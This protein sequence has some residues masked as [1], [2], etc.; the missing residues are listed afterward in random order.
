MPPSPGGSPHGRRGDE[1]APSSASSFLRRPWARALLGLVG[2][3][4]LAVFAWQVDWKA[5]SG[6]LVRL[7]PWVPLLLVPY[8]VVYL[9]DTVG[10]A[11]CLNRFP[12]ISYWR[13]FR[14]RW[15]GEAV[16]SLVPS[17]YIAGE[18]VKVLLLGRDGVSGSEG[19]A[20]AVVSKTLQ[21]V[22]QLAFIALGA[23]AML[24]LGTAPAAFA[25]AAGFVMAAGAFLLAGFFA[26]QQR[27]L[28]TSLLQVTSAVGLR[29]VRW[30]AAL[31]RLRPMDEEVRRFHRERRGRFAG[32]VCA[33]FAGWLLDSVEI[34]AVA[35][36]LDV[37]L[38][39]KQA[40]AIEAFTGLVKALS[41]VIP[42]A[43]G[44]QESGIVVLCRMTGVEG[45]FGA[46][47]ALFR[48]LRE[49]AFA[50]VGWKLLLLDRVRLRD[51]KRAPAGDAGGSG[52]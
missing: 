12:G 32:S 17:A 52:R 23:W 51:L 16:N 45:P 2:A 37:P 39:W 14:V 28:A 6:L 42:G 31:E 36:V 7:G 38:G 3:A 11:L 48:R 4:L 20:S 43:I 18:T 47:Y 8:A 13:L 5:T 41:V 25:G 46:A 33:Y 9:A 19:A 22:G 27:G 34:L 15:A 26:V 44:V 30:R 1:P 50:G 49:L 24:S 21:S 40:I 10:W 29:S 35:W